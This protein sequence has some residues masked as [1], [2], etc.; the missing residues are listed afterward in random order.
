MCRV[1]IGMKLC[2]ACYVL[3]VCGLGQNLQARGDGS[4]AMGAGVFY[5]TPQE[6]QA[7]HAWGAMSSTVRLPPGNGDARSFGYFSSA[8]NLVHNHQLW[9]NNF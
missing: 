6:P 4:C 2:V 5:S 7:R 8:K 3:T 1:R 9:H